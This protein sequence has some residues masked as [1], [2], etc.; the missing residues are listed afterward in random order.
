MEP[1]VKHSIRECT[2]RGEPVANLSEASAEPGFPMVSDRT[3]RGLV[4]EIE[5]TG[6]AVLPGFISLE[7]LRKLQEF[8]VATVQKS[9][10]E[11]TALNGK[12]AVAGTLLADLP[13]HR[14]FQSLV[15]RIYECATA[16]PAPSQSIYQVLRCLAGKTGL[17]QSFIFHYDSY[18]VTVLLPILIPT[19]GRRGH[20]VMAPNIR[21]IHSAYTRNLLDKLIVDNPLTQICLRLLHKSNLLRLTRIELVPGN[22]YIFWGY[23]TLHANEACD[24]ENIRSTALFH[25]GDPHGNSRLRRAMGRAAV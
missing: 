7:Q 9:D 23:R 21:Q 6:F 5:R 14:A 13:D 15:R 17:K 20:L 25:F 12:G 10:G 18:V 1:S 16:S 2:V 4:A 24:I 19:I 3:V 22:L 11:Y 8:V